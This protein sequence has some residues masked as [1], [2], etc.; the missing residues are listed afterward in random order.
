[1][2]VKQ[3]FDLMAVLYILNSENS[4][5]TCVFYVLAVS[6]TQYRIPAAKLEPRCC[7]DCYGTARLVSFVNQIILLK[8]Y[9]TKLLHILLEAMGL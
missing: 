5:S 2:L 4:H 1:M 6:M 3:V 9:P 8:S 7:P